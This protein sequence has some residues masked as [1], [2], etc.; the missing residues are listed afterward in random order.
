MASRGLGMTY[1]ETP[2]K[3]YKKPKQQKPKKDITEVNKEQF[4]KAKADH[5]AEIAKIKLN[6]KQEKQD[7]KRHKMLIKQAK[8]TYKLT[9]MKAS[10]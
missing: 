7:I 3:P 9:Q 10:K 5:K 6:R 8:I 1:E 2:A 4:Q